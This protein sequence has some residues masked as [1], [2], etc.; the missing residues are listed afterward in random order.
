MSR[1]N[2]SE[3]VWHAFPPMTIPTPI[4]ALAPA[5]DGL[6]AAG[7]GGI[8]RLRDDETWQLQIASLP[9]RSLTA[10]AWADGLLLAGGIG[11]LARSTDRGHSWRLATVEEPFASITAFAVSPQFSREQ[12]ILAATVNSGIMRSE[13]GGQKWLTANSGLQTFEINALLW[14]EG[15]RVLAGTADGMYRSTNGGRAWH[16]VRGTEGLVVVALAILPDGTLVAAPEEGEMLASTDGGAHWEAHGELP[17]DVSCSSLWTTPQ[18]TLLLSSSEQGLLRSTSTGREWVQVLDDLVLSCV[19]AGTRPYAGTTTGVS[20]SDDDGQSWHA[21]PTPP[22][23]DVQH[24]H[25]LGEQLL[26]SGAQAGLLRVEQDSWQPVDSL[27]S[28]LTSVFAQ[29]QALFVASAQGLQRSDDG[30]HNWQTV[31][32]GED[33][34][35]SHLTLR[36]DGH[37]WAGCGDEARLLRSRD[38]GMHW[39]A[40]AAPFGVLSLI[41]LQA[42][43]NLVV[44]ATYDAHLLSGQIWVS[45]DEGE[46]WQRV[47]DVQPLLSPIIFHDTPP[48]IALSNRILFPSSLHADR[49]RATSLD[50]QKHGQIRR[51]IGKPHLL[52]MLTT[53]G[54][55]YSVDS[56]INWTR[57]DLGLP[58]EEVWDVALTDDTLYIL[59]A[60]GRVRSCQI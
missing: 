50:E 51:V 6:R 7:M 35:V 16:L 37:G 21:L 14:N 3:R 13:D 41:G 43:S 47:I 33:G 59:L 49:W 10:L 54:L 60:G 11:G 36:A 17:A 39:Q 38:G 8:A 56:G 5:E 42:M 20:V 45:S 15:E 9:L 28:T 18:G 32:A 27:P 29:Q 2:M 4:L 31:I 44:A 26:C 19:V 34:N 57:V 48:L 25:L 58:L 55:F 24:L 40:L 53:I 46:H 22:L 12:T 23:G 1:I 52:L 30:G